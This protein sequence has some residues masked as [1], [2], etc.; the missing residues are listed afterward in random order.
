VARD[1]TYLPVSLLADVS[2]REAPHSRSRRI[3]FAQGDRAMF[4][5]IEGLPADTSALRATGMVTAADY[6]QTIIPLAKQKMAAHGKVRVLMHYGPGFT[7]YSP[8]AMWED[9]RFG[10]SHL[11]DFSKIA[12]VSDVVWLRHRVWLFAPF[13]RCPVHV[14]GNDE[15]D[16]AKTWIAS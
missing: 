15:L 8:S 5:L 13:I 16:A 1:G 6:Q 12:V 3:S 4:E 7:G 9:T 14:F 11:G 2:T 10:L